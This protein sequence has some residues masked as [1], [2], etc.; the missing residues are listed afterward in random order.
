M[1]P[2]ASQPLVRRGQSRHLLAALLFA[3]GCSGTGSSCGSSCG[4]AVTTTLPDGGPF[5]YVGSKLDNTITFRITQDGLDQLN[6]QALNQVI[7]NLGG[8]AGVAYNIP[9]IG[10]ISLL[11]CSTSFGTTQLNLIAGDE[12]FDGQCTAADGT[13]LHLTFNNVVFTLDP[14]AQV[15]H[16]KIYVNI[17]SGDFY[18]RTVEAHSSICKDGSGNPASIQ[19]DVQIDD[20]Q[21]IAGQTE[22][23]VDLQFTTA[24]DGRLLISPTQ[25]SLDAILQGIDITGMLFL[26]AAPGH[27]P[28]PPATA[29]PSAN[30]CDAD[31][32][33]YNT[34][35]GSTLTCSGWT[36]GFSFGCTPDSTSMSGIGCTIAQYIKQYLESFLKSTFQTQIIGLVQQQLDNLECDRPVDSTGKPVACDSGHPCGKDDNGTQEICDPTYSVCDYAGQDAGAPQNC[37]PLAL[38]LQAQV[39]LSGLTQTVGFPAGTKLNVYAGL[40]GKTASS[41]IDDGGVQLTAVSGTQPASTVVP[42]LCVP[43]TSI[44]PLSP[45]IL[46][47]NF[48]DPNNQPDGGVGTYDIGIA[49][50]SQ[51]LNRAAYDAFNAGALCLQISNQT[52]SFVSTQLFKTFL[53]SLGLLTHGTDA[54]MAVLLRPSAAPSVR[55]GRGTLTT[56][57]MNNVEP[58]DP[59]ITLTLPQLNLD[60]YAVIEERWVRLFTLTTDVSLPIGLRT[61]PGSQ[62]DTLQPV[63]GDL[64]M[65]LGNISASGNV[66]LAEDPSV[67]TDLLGAVINFAQPLLAGVLKPV[68]L[69]QIAGLALEVKGVDGAIPLSS[70]I[71]Q[72]GYQHLAIWAGVATCGQPNQPACSNRAVHTEARLSQSLLPSSAEELRTHKVLPTAIIDAQSFGV[73]HGHAEYSYRIDGGLWSP[74]I[75]SPHLTI[76]NPMFYVQGHHKIEVMSR[77]SGNDHTLDLHPA[78]VDFLSSYEPPSASLTQLADGRV[79]TKAISQASMPIQ[80]RYSYRIGDGAWSVPGPA[81]D[82]SAAELNGQGLAVK[83][84]DE[85]GM[86]SKATLGNVNV[87]RD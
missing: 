65:V 13:P 41:V 37:E 75:A 14:A 73:E 7:G 82:F 46:A 36:D 33:P 1:L 51:M 64:S 67:V 69:P 48:D 52:S 32:T 18:L 3:V 45:N 28:A 68:E 23:D 60:F 53:P 24:P 57:S 43:P 38:A 74:W 66:M 9:C 31:S 8:D 40:G 83:V 54:P 25:S 56:D 85:R 84:V 70:N 62:A 15:L 34:M 26:A 17:K 10:P 79:I 80:L 55:I 21:S 4:G 2:S 5:K 49:L 87:D 58:L 71:Q 29:V 6:A 72:D 61:F 42:S 39:D 35:N 81:R 50:A 63:L 59:L 76:Q 22:L 78:V 44:P 77:E 12:N 30:G 19:A 47:M 16:T 86:E 11:S 27:D 20:S